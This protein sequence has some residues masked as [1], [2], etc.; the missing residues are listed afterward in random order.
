M[1]WNADMFDLQHKLV[2]VKFDAVE[3]NKVQLDK[4][5]VDA[6]QLSD[7]HGLEEWLQT[8]IISML[9]EMKAEIDALRR[10]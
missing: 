3:L 10:R 9:V 5:K 2:S 1:S 8:H 4:A 6:A 7:M